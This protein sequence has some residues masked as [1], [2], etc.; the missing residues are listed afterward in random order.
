MKTYF[1]NIYLSPNGN[2]WC[3]SAFTEWDDALEDMFNH[4]GHLGN[5]YLHTATTNGQIVKFTAE[6]VAHYKELDAFER[7]NNTVL[8]NFYDRRDNA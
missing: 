5:T 4:D 1:C 2:A 8:Q 3:E 7:Q 6:D